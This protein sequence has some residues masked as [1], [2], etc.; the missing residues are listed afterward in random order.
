MEVSKDGAVVRKSVLGCA[1]CLV[2]LL[3]VLSWD[4]N[5]LFVS[6]F[7]GYYCVC[8]FFLDDLFAKY[9]RTL[10]QRYTKNMARSLGQT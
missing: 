6:S 5:S 7:C 3:L 1:F 4:E 10:K 2:C 9:C 8:I